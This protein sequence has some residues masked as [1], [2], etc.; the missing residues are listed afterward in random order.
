MY[1]TFQTLLATGRA[2]KRFASQ[3]E[4]YCTGYIQSEAK[5]DLIACNL[6]KKMEFPS[7]CM[8]IGVSCP[9]QHET[10]YLSHSYTQ[11]NTF[12]L[13]EQPPSTA[14]VQYSEPCQWF[15]RAPPAMCVQQIIPERGQ[16]SH[17]HSFHPIP[18]AIQCIQSIQTH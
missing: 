11:K 8:G 10:A 3:A 9:Q 7:R 16:R 12:Y 1:L 17:Y 15:S 13:S 18:K 5:S 6:K 2:R 14:Y 4:L